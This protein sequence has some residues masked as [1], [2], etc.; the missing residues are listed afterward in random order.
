MTRASPSLLCPPV[1]TGNARRCFA[2]PKRGASF[3]SPPHPT[4]ASWG[5]AVKRVG[6]HHLRAVWFSLPG[7]CLLLTRPEVRVTTLPESLSPLSGPADG[8]HFPGDKNGRADQEMPLR[9]VMSLMRRDTVQISAPEPPDGLSLDHRG[10][11][12]ERL[13][14]GWS[15]GWGTTASSLVG[16]S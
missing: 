2:T 10:K 13:C 5:A 8:R 16:S 9:E 15:P 12:L 7:P 3:C 14:G 4:L 1:H 6:R 11:V